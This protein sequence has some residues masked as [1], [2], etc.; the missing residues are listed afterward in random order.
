MSDF[1]I[2]HNPRCSKSRNT[3]AILRDKGI[4]PDVVQ[5]LDDPPSATEIRALIAKLGVP[6]AQLVR[7]GEP[8]YKECGLGKESTDAELIAAMASH[9]KLIERPIVVRGKRAVIGRPPENVLDLLT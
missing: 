1:L 8:A 6:V 3:L 2:Y 5:Y 7:S 4:E 9:P